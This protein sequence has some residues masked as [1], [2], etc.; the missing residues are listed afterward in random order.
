MDDR[1]ADVGGVLFWIL[2]ITGAGLIGRRFSDRAPGGGGVPHFLREFCREAFR[3][4]S[5][6]LL[7]LRFHFRLFLFYW[8]A[9]NLLFCQ[10]A[11]RNRTNSSGL[12]MVNSDA[13]LNP[14]K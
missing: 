9:N 7:L 8:S 3:K 1:H 10:Q 11:S 6:V 13:D 12:A 4:P 2:V 5:C 14:E